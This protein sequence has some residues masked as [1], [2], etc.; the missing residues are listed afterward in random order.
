[1]ATPLLLVLML[2]EVTDLDLRDRLDPGDLRRDTR[3]VH[4]LHVEHLRHPGP[5]VALLPAGRGGRP[6]LPA[7]VRPRRDPQFVGVKMLGEHWFDIDILL[8][9]A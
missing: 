2:V 4:R 9:L 8:S 3:S 5:A 6:I 1:M 7:E